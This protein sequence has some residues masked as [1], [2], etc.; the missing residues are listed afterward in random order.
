MGPF[1]ELKK[2]AAQP[3]RKKREQ[4]DKNRFFAPAAHA[5]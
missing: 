4:L 1:S 5:S 3:N 2:R